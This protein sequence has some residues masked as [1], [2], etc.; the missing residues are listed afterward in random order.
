MGSM[1]FFYPGMKV[2]SMDLSPN[3]SGTIMAIVNG[4]G[5]ITGII[6]P[7]L[8]GVLTPNVSINRGIQL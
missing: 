5:G 6:T 2:N 3:Y 1:G 8:V 4:I 7:Y